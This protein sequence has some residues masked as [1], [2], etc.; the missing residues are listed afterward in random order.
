MRKPLAKEEGKRKRFRA[1]IDRLGKKSNF[2]GYTEETVLLKNLVD[3]ETNNV[4]TDHLWVSLTKGFEKI[5]LK[6]G[7]MIEFDARVKEYKK[8]YVNS[9]FKTSPQ[10]RDYKLSHPT[11]IKEVSSLLPP[12]E[13]H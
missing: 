6:I 5:S 4:V 10:Q 13:N 3:I 8:G 1:V 11:K 2:K 7:M 9:K 12:N